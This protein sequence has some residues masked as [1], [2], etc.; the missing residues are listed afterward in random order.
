MKPAMTIQN[1]AKSIGFENAAQAISEAGFKLVNFSPKGEEKTASLKLLEKYGLSVYQ[2]HAPI[3][4]DVRRD[5]PFERKHDLE[6]L[7]TTAELGAKYMVVHG[8]K[9]DFKNLRYSHDA[10]LA[11]NYEYY[12]PIVEEASRLNVK[13]A[14]ENVFQELC[15]IPHFCAL[16]EEHAELIDKFGSESACACWDVGHAAMQHKAYQ[17]DAIKV[18]GKRI[19]CTHIHDNYMW[20]EDLHIPPFFGK[21][22]WSDCMTALKK[23]GSSDVLCLELQ[24]Q[25]KNIPL[26]LA[27]IYTE[28]LYKICLLLDEIN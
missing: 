2:T 6:M 23:H 7:R 13:I 28:F 26:G 12:A 22:E 25:V 27:K 10:A 21:I 24:P 9:F 5:A 11:F 3:L 1:I 19:E 8:D 14:F 20:L 4:R 17:S 15:D 16:P 18:L